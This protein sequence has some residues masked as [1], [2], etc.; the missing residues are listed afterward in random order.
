VAALPALYFDSNVTNRAARLLAARG[1]DVRMA[2]DV[3]MQHAID[4]EH[5]L[6]AAQEGWLLVT[7][8][9][10]FLDLHDAWHLWSRAWGV[11]PRHGGVL[12]G[13]QSWAY[14]K[15]AAEVEAFVAQG[16]D[17]ANTLYQWRWGHG[18]LARPVP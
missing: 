3:G 6:R 5:L 4:A 7:N 2:A 11:E 16:I 9:T 12:V 8:D 10:D 1:L 13:I 17:P 15:V 14:Q 18:W